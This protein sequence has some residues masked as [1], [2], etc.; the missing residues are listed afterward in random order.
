LSRDVDFVWSSVAIGDT[1]NAVRFAIENKT[2]LLLSSFPAVN[3]Y[4]LLADLNTSKEE[5]WA[6]LAY[7]AYDLGLVP[8]SGKI[9]SIRIEPDF[10]KV[11]TKSEKR[12]TIAYENINLFSLNNISGLE[13]E[14]DR[15]FCYNEVCDWFDLRS[16]GE[17]EP[18]FSIPAGS[19]I[20]A[21]EPYPSHRRDGYEYYDVYSISH[22]SDSQLMDYEYS[23][24]YIKFMIQKYSKQQNIDLELWKRD[25][26]K[27]YQIT[28]KQLR[29][30]I[31]WL[32]ETHETC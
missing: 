5:V 23:D 32:G 2:S 31:N 28:P 18:S 15:N 1:I 14:F 21:I 24:T 25:V 12:Y 17:E 30:N 8:F 26:R 11:F 29:K 10:I 20:Q 3:S 4:E 16:G 13:S 22:L 9:K 19:V 7:E 27:V 6:S